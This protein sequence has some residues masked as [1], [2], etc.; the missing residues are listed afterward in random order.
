MTDT[1][2]N[3]I[4]PELSAIIISYLKIDDFEKL[5]SFGIK[6]FEDVNWWRFAFSLHFGFYFKNVDQQGYTRWLKMEK[7]KNVL[8]L[9]EHIM[10]LYILKT[11]YLDNNNKIVY[12][13][14]EIGSLLKLEE[15]NLNNNQIVY[16]P[17]SIADLTN[18]RTLS[19][20]NN[21]LKEIPAAIIKLTNLIFLNLSNNQIKEIPLEITKLKNLNFLNLNYNQIKEVS[22]EIEGFMRK[23]KI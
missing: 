12:V 9:K 13:P 10:Q 3:S 7:L 20:C 1:Y 16:V 11:L 18:L 22:P 15:L 4:P 14:E 17:P 6:T 5:M 19:L 23:F 2:F 8:G 21:Q